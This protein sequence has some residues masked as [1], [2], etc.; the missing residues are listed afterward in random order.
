MKAELNS[1][2]SHQMFP[3]LSSNNGRLPTASQE[4]SGGFQ[5]VMR[6]MEKDMWGSVNGGVV[7]AEKLPASK[8]R[9]TN[10]AQGHNTLQFVRSTEYFVLQNRSSAV[11]TPKNVNPQ[12]K[13]AAID[14]ASM[15]SIPADVALNYVA[16][17]RQAGAGYASALA[18]NNAAPGDSDAVG[19]ANAD[20]SQQKVVPQNAIAQDDEEVPIR[21]T[22]MQGETGVSVAVR[23]HGNGS[24]E[25]LT[26]QQKAL[27][28]LRRQGLVSAKIIVNGQEQ[29]ISSND[30]SI[31]GKIHG[32]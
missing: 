23:T 17:M 6:N 1:T 22:V 24:V 29:P 27:T 18:S 10:N 15:R 12:E 30:Y 16:P 26:L 8:N 3:S 4:L 20:I 7:S 5:N 25:T 19:A 14:S 21:V 28:A 11:S 13:A 9:L 31:P 2:Y 32:N